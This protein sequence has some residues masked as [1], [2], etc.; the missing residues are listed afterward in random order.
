M[1]I[2]ET[3]HWYVTRACNINPF[4]LYCFDPAMDFGDHVRPLEEIAWSVAMTKNHIKTVIETGGEP[5]LAR[6]LPEANRI[7]HKT[8]GIEVIL[9][10]NGTTL[11]EGK[12]RD[13]QG[14]VQDV[15]LP[16]DS[17]DRKVQTM[18]K[19]YDH[20]P[21]FE[22]AHALLS[23]AGIK[24]GVH[25]VATTANL[26]GIPELYDYL[27]SKGFDY[28]RVY[29]FNFSLALNKVFH[30]P[31][32]TRKD[33]IWRINRIAKVE[34]L[35]G[36]RYRD[37]EEIRS[38][39]FKADFDAMRARLSKYHDKRVEFVAIDESDEPYVFLDDRG[40]ILY[41]QR[42]MNFKMMDRMPIGNLCEGNTLYPGFIREIKRRTRILERMRKWELEHARKRFF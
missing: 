28:W 18:L 38:R 33:S 5:T 20:V 25:T 34:A 8:A 15:A 14:I 10:T 17:I 9:H 2:G 16:L 12:V 21:V 6:E 39:R 13:M 22:R 42:G 23:N 7:L 4:C 41:Y 32:R 29:E 35:T 3:V 26:A 37:H 31:V 1:A 27:D 40:N 30:T 19:G 36:V 11:D 24:V